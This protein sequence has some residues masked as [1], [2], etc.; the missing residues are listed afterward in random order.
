MTYDILKCKA[1][2][3]TYGF[4]KFFFYSEVKKRIIEIS[5]DEEILKNKNRRAVFLVKNLRISPEMIKIIGEKGAAVFLID[6]YPLFK[7]YATKRGI[8]L[9]QMRKF[10]EFCVKYNAKY[11]FAT[12]FEKENEI[13]TPEEIIDLLS[14]V[15]VNEGQTRF[16]LEE[17][18][19]YF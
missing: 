13:R 7:F 3:G 10:L 6:L 8:Y 12:F 1:D 14:L 5:S 16:A 17:L 2:A 18:G 15:G 11:S 19:K 9:S 4:T